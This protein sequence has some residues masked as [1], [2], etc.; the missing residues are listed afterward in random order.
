M[1][2]KCPQCNKGNMQYNLHGYPDFEEV[3]KTEAL[4][5][6]S[7]NI[8][9]CA[10]P[11]AGVK[12][13]LYSCDSCEYEMGDI[14]QLEKYE[15][16]FSIGGFTHGR[17]RI[18]WDGTFLNTY[19]PRTEEP[20]DIYIVDDTSWKTFWNTMDEINVWKWEKEYFNEGMMDGEQWELC[21]KRKGRRKR[22]IFGSNAYPEPEI[23]FK[24]FINA[25]NDL[26][27]DEFYIWEVG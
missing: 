1:I 23:N 18:F 8:K 21:I 15:L 25:I 14:D 4:Y 2:K 9:G 6:I 7:A 24:K 26:I 20:T 13:Y 27:Q 19:K 5:G 22:K 16:D 12:T 17:N 11:L 10:P 3:Q